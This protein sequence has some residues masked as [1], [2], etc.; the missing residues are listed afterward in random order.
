MHLFGISRT[1]EEQ[2]DMVVVCCV[3]QV[4]E[5]FDGLFSIANVLGVK[6]KND[7]GLVFKSMVLHNSCTLCGSLRYNA[8]MH[9][10]VLVCNCMSS[11]SMRRNGSPPCTVDRSFQTA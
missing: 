1:Q 3:E 2:E 5:K 6:Y 8:M 4:S 10:L 7:N 11:L 9:V